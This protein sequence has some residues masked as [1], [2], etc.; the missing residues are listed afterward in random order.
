MGVLGQRHGAHAEDFDHIA[1]Q[2]LGDQL[3]RLAFGD[4]LAV[5]QHQQARAQA[6]GLVHEVGGQQDGSALLQQQLQPLPHQVAGLRVEAGGGFVQQQQARAVDEGAGQRQAPLHP[7]RE[8]ARLGVCFVRERG[9]LQ[10][11]GHALVHGAALE[12][13]VTAKH[14][15][16]FGA[17]EVRV[18][19]V[20][21][22]DHAQLC[23]DGQRI[24]RHVQRLGRALGVEQHVAAVGRRQAQAHADGG[25]LARPVGADD[26]KAFAGSDG[27]RHIVHHRGI[28]VVLVQVLDGKKFAHAAIV[29]ALGSRCFSA[30][31]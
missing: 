1:F 16:V 10:Q 23:L 26:A 9:K 29:A 12:P 15:Q 6:L 28:A 8:F 11:L 4:F 17:G 19:R 24:A 30:C 13:E 18:Q 3:A 20:E 31:G 7:A 25:G 14:A 21:L 22:G 27:K 2:V 5:V